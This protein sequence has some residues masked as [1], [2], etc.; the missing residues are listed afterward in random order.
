MV[1]QSCRVYAL[2]E[3]D[4]NTTLTRFIRG[5]DDL[6]G[7]QIPCK[8]SNQTLNKTTQTNYQVLSST[9]PQSMELQYGKYVQVAQCIKSTN[10]ILEQG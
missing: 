3:Y 5:P 9:I 7:I 1:S 6:K 8:C 4:Q 10:Y 2:G